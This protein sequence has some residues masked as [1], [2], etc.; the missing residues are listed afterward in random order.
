MDPKSPEHLD[1]TKD[2]ANEPIHSDEGEL[3]P[4]HGDELRSEESFGRTDRY[5]NID[6]Q[7]AT[8]EAADPEEERAEAPD[9]DRRAP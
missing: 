4:P 9:I 2:V 8:R 5:S 3:T 6:D 1:D 7:D